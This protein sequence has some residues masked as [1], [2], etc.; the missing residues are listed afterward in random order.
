MLTPAPGYFDV[1]PAGAG[2]KSKVGVR[3]ILEPGRQFFLRKTVNHGMAKPPVGGGKRYQPNPMKQEF[4]GEHGPEEQR[5]RIDIEYPHPALGSEYAKHFPEHEFGIAPSVQAFLADYQVER[6]VSERK[7]P[8]FVQNEL[9]SGAVMLFRLV[10]Q[11]TEFTIHADGE[12]KG[13]RPVRDKLPDQVPGAA[14]DL[15]NPV[16]VLSRLAEKFHG[17]LFGTFFLS[18]LR[19]FDVSA[20][21]AIAR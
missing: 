19:V 10:P 1:E 18:A 8:V 3:E 5:A 9:G 6:L 11:K 21:E 16:Y 12:N 14:A 13:G 17:E 7:V 2:K 20:D 15:E 4:L